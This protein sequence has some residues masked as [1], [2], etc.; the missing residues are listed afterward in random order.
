MQETLTVHLG[1]AGPLELRHADVTTSSVS[2]ETAAS[3]DAG[4]LGRKI[5]LKKDD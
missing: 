5:A 1:P 2:T 3:K 4:M